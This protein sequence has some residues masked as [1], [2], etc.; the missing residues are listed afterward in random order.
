MG[1]KNKYETNIKPH[2]KEVRELAANLTEYQIA[3]KFGVT[4]Q[5]LESYKKNY[6]ELLEALRDGKKDLV[7]ELKMTLI[8]KAKGFT[9]TESK[10]TLREEGG[11]KIKVVEKYEKY[12]QPDTGAIHLLLKNLDDSWRNDDKETIDQKR[13]QLELAERKVDQNEW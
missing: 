3:R 9:Y 1:R 2:L 4:P 11:K 12:A 10:Q 6:P 13:K 5:S 7:N 8:K